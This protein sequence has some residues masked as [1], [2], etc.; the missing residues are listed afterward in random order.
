MSRRGYRSACW[1]CVASLALLAVPAAARAE[2]GIL[3]LD[4]H[5]R[6]HRHGAAKA[7]MATAA[8]AK[9]VR[10]ARAAKTKRTVLHELKRL[11]ASGELSPAD[12][13]LR[14]TAYY[15]AKRAD[16]K[17][18]GTRRRELAAVIAI[19]DDVARRGELTASRLPA[20]WLT[21]QRNQEW[22]TSGPLMGSGQR[23]GFDGSELVWQYYPGAGLQIQWLGTF[24][25]LNWLARYKKYNSRSTVLTDEILGLASER[26]GGL[27]WEYL[28]PFDGGSPPWVSSLA[29]GTGL[30]ALAK[31]AKR[32]GRQ[33]DI[34]PVTQRALT[35]FETAPPEGVRVGPRSG[36][37]GP[38]YLQYSFASRLYILNGF[39]QAITGL[40]DYAQAT[41]DPTAQG[42][43]TEGEAE[44]RREVPEY[45]TGAWSL[46]SLGS[47][48]YESSLS[49]H[50][51]LK[52]FLVNMCDRTQAD[53]YCQTAARF[54][55]YELEP[56]VL[57]LADQRMRGGKAG[58]LRVRLSKVSS[59]SVRIQ[60]Q[61]K[62]VMS[63]ALGTV[64]HGLIRVRWDVP[65]RKGTY[66]VTVSARDLNGHTA[67]QTGTVQVLKPR[68]RG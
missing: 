10:R 9:R 19:V 18:Q 30:Q 16:R 50:E 27:A 5:G 3:V 42:L 57:Q 20:L 17:L 48:S 25:K 64:G 37:A 49:Y 40:Y 34:F 14:R 31:A 47:G 56:P 28:F 43:Y 51:L 58:T 68:K 52:G 41:Q 38:H 6:V 46:Y 1:A 61:S 23:T 21:L 13:V 12:Y 36:W 35:I 60:R 4:G 59:L 11:R 53:V 63:R 55:D 15:D 45:D 33:A 65:R 39:T 67:E 44:L 22:W 66:D 32:L 7:T 2:G 8:P 24:G 62:V 54:G 29:Q 26:A